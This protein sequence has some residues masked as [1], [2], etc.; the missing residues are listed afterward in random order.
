MG[1]DERPPLTYTDKLR[2]YRE[3]IAL[4]REETAEA[5]ALRSEAQ[6]LSPAD[7]VWNA[8]DVEILRRRTMREYAKQK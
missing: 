5:K 4:D 6:Q 3:L 8:I 2:R 7:P 1:V